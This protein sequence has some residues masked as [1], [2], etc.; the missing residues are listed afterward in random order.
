[1]AVVEARNPKRCVCVLWCH[2]DTFCCVTRRPLCTSPAPDTHAVHA[3]TTEAEEAQGACRGHQRC[4]VHQAAAVTRL[5]TQV[6]QGVVRA[7]GGSVS[8][9]LLHV[10]N[11]SHAWQHDVRRWCV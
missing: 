2:A 4:A 10:L 5:V 9:L 1:M 6:A 11:T 3:R 7:W 8:R